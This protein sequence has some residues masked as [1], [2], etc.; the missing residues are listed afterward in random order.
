MGNTPSKAS[1]TIMMELLTHFPCL[2]S[3]PQGNSSWL[4]RHRILDFIEFGL[5]NYKSS[6][7]GKKCI[8]LC[9]YA[10]TD[11][12]R[13]IH[14][15]YGIIFSQF[16]VGLKFWSYR[17]YQRNLGLIKNYLILHWCS[18]KLILHRIIPS[19]FVFTY[20]SQFIE[21]NKFLHLNT[22]F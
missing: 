6:W 12:R 14:H 11:K 2:A 18:L 10:C 5:Q 8:C 13:N 3:L 7:N 17:S 15:F 9:I 4:R 22:L 19:Q 21:C 1:Y 16:I 20:Q